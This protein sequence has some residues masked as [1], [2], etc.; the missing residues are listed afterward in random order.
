MSVGNNATLTADNITMTASF[1]DG[2]NYIAD[3]EVLGA[4]GGVLAGVS[5]SE[6]F[7]DVDTNASVNIASNASVNV[8]SLDA[9]NNPDNGDSAEYCCR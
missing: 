5:G 1:A 3:A 2:T 9:G 4:S 8:N 7:I 6:N